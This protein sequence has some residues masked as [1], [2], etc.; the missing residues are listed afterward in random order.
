V[1]TPKGRVLSKARPDL[2]EMF[3]GYCQR[4]SWQLGREQEVNNTLG[5]L[6]LAASPTFLKIGGFKEDG[7]NWPEAADRI[8]HVTDYLTQEEKDAKARSDREWDEH[9][10]NKEY[11]KPTPAPA[12]APTPA[13]PVE[14]E[15][16]VE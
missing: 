1:K 2:G 10:K 16:P 3:M 15:V 13:P 12:P 5:S 4:V 7:S 6:I 8:Y 14:V 9:W 11:N